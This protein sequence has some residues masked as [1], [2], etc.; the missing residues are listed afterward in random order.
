MKM[1]VANPSKKKKQQ[2]RHR[3]NPLPLVIM[4]PRKQRSF[5]MAKKKSRKHASVG[6]HRPRHNPFKRRRARH[7]P[8]P[9]S[10]TNAVK[11]VLGGA[12]GLLATVY[13][14][15][16]LFGMFGMADTGLLA[17][18]AAALVAFLPPWLLNKYPNL[19]QG[20]LAGGGAGFVWRVVDD[21]TGHPYLSISAQ[22]GTGSFIAPASYVLP[23][24]N[25]FGPYGRRALPAATLQ[26]TGAVRAATPVNAAGQAS[27]V[28]M[29]WV[30]YPYAA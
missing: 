4:N 1:F 10:G 20:W 30:R 18:A 3:V 21:L 23:G 9:V 25:V 14:P 26:A 15:N 5:V 22:P 11:V 17:Y 29:G 27:P 28:G 7:N 19:A 24:P 6:Q 2:K 13:I 16:W 8:F 12:T